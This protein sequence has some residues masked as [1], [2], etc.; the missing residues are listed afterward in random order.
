[1][2]RPDFKLDIEDG[3][4]WNGDDPVQISNK[5]FHLLR[6]FVE[7]PNRLL[8][9]EQILD[10]VWGDIC[11]SEGLIKE[12]VRDLR[13]ALGDNARNPQFIETVRGRGYRFLGGVSIMSR[14]N[15]R[16]DRRSVLPPT[17]R[18]LPLTDVFATQKS[19]RICHGLTDDL[20]TDL[21][22]FSD[23]VVIADAHPSFDSGDG[24]GEFRSAL[25]SKQI[26]YTLAGSVQVSG[27]S[28]R[29]NVRLV[30]SA[31]GC[32]I[33]AEQYDR[34]LGKLFSVQD[35]I[36]A[37]V[38]SAVGGLS[39]QI[40]IAERTR[41]RRHLPSQLNAYE[42]YLLAHELETHF[43]QVDTLKAIELVEQ[44]LEIDAEFARA[45]LVLG[46]LSWQVVVENWSGD[47]ERYKQTWIASHEK[48]ATLDSLDPFAQMEF[49]AIRA[50]QGDEASAKDALERALDL[51]RNQ[52]DLLI[53]A[54]NYVAILLGEPDRAKELMDRGF[55]MILRTPKWHHLTGLRVSY[56]CGEYERALE[57]ARFAP[58]FLPKII[59]EILSLAQLD[60][61]DAVDERRRAL[62]D[63]RPK[64]DYLEFAKQ[65]P[66]TASTSMA[67]YLDGAAKAGFAKSNNLLKFA[68]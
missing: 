31:S 51:G 38:A 3:R 47:V 28:L 7:N 34:S 61:N 12:Y 2:R 8:T 56:F 36:V 52:A 25:S 65:L 62:M 27:E 35:D 55:A 19:A 11:V 10:D 54:A 60:H 45:W 24:R 9:K 20:I 4:L 39:G 5:A 67:R 40:S 6:L 13:L 1:M 30:E 18:V 22:R 29:A 68:R 14:D 42:L 64:F 50:L 37:H 59:F 49:A 63:Q 48:A 44:A 57:H 41:L 26:S 66:I 23:L 46:W 15:S 16:Y 32:V 21:A 33:W 53:A 17:L 58:D 43:D